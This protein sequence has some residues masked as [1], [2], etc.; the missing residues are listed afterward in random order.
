[1]S[2]IAPNAPDA[3]SH[4]SP[5]DRDRLDMLLAAYGRN[6]LR[7]PESD[8]QRFAMLVRAPHLLPADAAASADGLDRLLDL[9]G[10]A[11]L[12]EPSGAR[13]R[14]MQRV[15][16]EPQLATDITAPPP[17]TGLRGLLAAGMLAASLV[18]GAFIGVD[19]DA[20]TTLADSL[21]APSSTDE[22]LDVV[23]ADPAETDDGGVL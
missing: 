22:V 15:K 21:S 20:G 14:L 13:A 10:P 7:W 12:T 18:L 4:L 1:M 6:P 8:R 2:T 19:T 17:L 3:H 11:R 16:G 9:A 5:A 23:L